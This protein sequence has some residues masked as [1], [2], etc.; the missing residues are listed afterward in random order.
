MIDQKESLEFVTVR[1]PRKMWHAII[2]T[3]LKEAAQANA[4][5]VSTLLMQKLEKMSSIAESWYMNTP[6]KR[7]LWHVYEGYLTD[8]FRN[9]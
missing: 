8:L 3:C 7:F 5:D 2:D 1:L 4:S 9:K 6:M